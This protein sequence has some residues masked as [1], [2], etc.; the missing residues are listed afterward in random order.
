M[1]F[2]SQLI[3]LYKLFNNKNIYNLSN[4]SNPYSIPRVFPATLLTIRYFHCQQSIEF[5]GIQSPTFTSTNQDG[6]ISVFT[7]I[8]KCKL[9]QPRLAGKKSMSWRHH[10]VIARASTRIEF[11]EALL[12]FCKL[13]FSVADGK[14][15][16]LKYEDYI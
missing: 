16:S 6:N 7:I 8:L 10:D 12:R 15:P 13:G 14:F 1:T 9:L 5:L 2:P 3:L 11:Q 4:H